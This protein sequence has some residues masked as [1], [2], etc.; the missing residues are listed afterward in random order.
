MPP[1]K[2]K[3]NNNNNNINKIKCHSC[4]QAIETMKIIFRCKIKTKRDNAADGSH[5]VN[6]ETARKSVTSFS[7][8]GMDTTRSNVCRAALVK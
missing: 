4:H 7:Y 5:S 6:L 8:C 1:P 3:N 2:K